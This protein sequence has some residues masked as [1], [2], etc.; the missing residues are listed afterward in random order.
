[1]GLVIESPRL[2]AN[3]ARA[4]DGAYPN[5]AYQVVLNAQGNTDWKDGTDTVHTTDPETSWLERTIVRIE[6][7]L[8]IEWLL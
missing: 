3:L 2:A 8:P 5:A 4:V 6:S 7:W 1:M